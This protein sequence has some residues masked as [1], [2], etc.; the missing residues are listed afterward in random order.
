MQ[1]MNK[2]KSIDLF[3]LEYCRYP[4]SRKLRMD[5]RFQLKLTNFTEQ[6]SERELSL[7]MQLYK[8]ASK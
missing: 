1:R 2:N 4:L 5:E 3:F 6:R 7:K 8:A